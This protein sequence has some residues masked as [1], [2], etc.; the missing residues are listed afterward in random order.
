MEKERDLLWLLKETSLMLA[1]HDRELLRIGDLTPAEN[2][3]L[4]YFLGHEERAFCATDL[5]LI[6]GI[7]KPAI[8]TLLK[9]L[10]KKGYLQIEVLP[11][12]E[13]KKS[14][15]LTAKAYSVHEQIATAMREREAALCRGISDRELDLLKQLLNKLIA[16]MDQ[17]NRLGGMN[18]DQNTTSSSQGV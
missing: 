1:R 6:L 12:D 13:R 4:G 10:K 7:S 8:S 5:H 9:S 14:I 16:N 15:T 3:L 17:N 2:Y 18:L 11:Q